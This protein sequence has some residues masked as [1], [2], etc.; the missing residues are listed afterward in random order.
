MP[1]ASGRIAA[2]TITVPPPACGTAP[3]NRYVPCLFRLKDPP[4]IVVENP[5][6]WSVT[7]SAK[8]SALQHVLPAPRVKLPNTA[9]SFCPASMTANAEKAEKMTTGGAS[10][11][12]PRT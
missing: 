2:H 1:P 5:P 6:N 9:N 8:G 11:V 12:A 7:L 4:G 10:V 3:W